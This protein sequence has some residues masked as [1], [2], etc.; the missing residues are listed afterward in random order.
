MY[1][2]ASSDH[3]IVPVIND[4]VIILVNILDVSRLDCASF[5]SIGWNISFQN[6]TSIY[7]IEVVIVVYAIPFKTIER[8]Y[9]P[10]GLSYI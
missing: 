3:Y 9:R 10:T 6:M 2:V 5:V 7:Q 8:G 4:E 1:R